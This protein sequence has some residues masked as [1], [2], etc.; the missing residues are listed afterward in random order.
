MT[1]KIGDPVIHPDHGKLLTLTSFVD[2]L[3]MPPGASYEASGEM[4]AEDE[5]AWEKGTAHVKHVTFV[6]E[7][8]R[9]PSKEESAEMVA[10]SKLRPT[11]VITPRDGGEPFS[12]PRM[13]RLGG[14]VADLVWDSGVAA[15]RPN[16]RTTVLEDF[17]RYSR[18]ERRKED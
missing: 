8:G 9:L 16:R 10:A 17:S 3:G 1:P 13:M 2:K 11:L 5:E 18:Y 6:R 14:E 15:W 7:Q 12:K 4:T